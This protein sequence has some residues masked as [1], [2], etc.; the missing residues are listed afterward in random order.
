MPTLQLNV[1][2]R[3]S[4]LEPGGLSP[5]APRSGDQGA[6]RAQAVDGGAD[7]P[8]GVAGPLAAGVEPG[9]GRALRESRSSRGMRTG[10][11][12]R[13][14]GPVRVAS[15]R[16]RP[17]NRR[18]M[19]G[20]PRSRASSTSGGRI[21]PRSIGDRPA[22]IAARQRAAA[23]PAGEEVAGPLDRGGV[24]PAAGEV[25]QP[26]GPLLEV[27]ARQRV[28]AAGVRRVDRHDQPAVG[29]RRVVPALAHAVGAEV[30]GLAHAGHDVAAGAHAEGEQVA[31]AGAG[32]QVVIG[33]AQ[34][35]VAGVARRSGATLTCPCGCS[36]RTPSWNGLASSG[37]PRRSSI[38]YV[39]RA[40]W[41]IGQNGDVGRDVARAG[42]Q[43]R[44][45]GRPAM[46][47]SSTRH[48][49]RT[50]PPS[51]FELAPEGA[52]DQRQAVR[53]EVGP[54]LVEDRRLAVAVGEDLQHAPD[55]GAGA[56][57]GQLAV[58]ERARAPLAEEVVA[59]GVERR[60]RRRTGGRRRRGP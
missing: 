9:D 24:G 49:K 51:C 27:D 56:A 19:T 44:G 23:R 45:A 54:V 57:A 22:G 33:R 29:E 34:G 6:G 7:D 26:L 37:T 21:A 28:P 53:A 15:L 46:S 17:R 2:C 14:S 58:A 55:V 10:E 13:D 43:A 20:R 41:P 30:A 38:A 12:P 47:R 11:L 52:D 18:S 36:I 39:S 32:D 25:G 3:S 60:R 48:E 31:A 35:G 50:S 59:L 8:A 42:Q 4:A 1:R 5:R 16:N 40:L